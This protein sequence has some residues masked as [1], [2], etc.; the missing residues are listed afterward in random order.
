MTVMAVA[1]NREVLAQIEGIYRSRIDEFRRVARAVLGES[2]N[3][4][5]AVQDGFVRA[6]RDCHRFRG[7]GPLEGWVWG[8]V[9]N[10]IRESARALGK[11]RQSAASS[12]ALMD[13]VEHVRRDE[14]VRDAIQQLPERQRLALFLRH[15]AD[16]DYGEIAAALGIATGTVGATLHAAHAA[17][18]EALK[19]DLKGEQP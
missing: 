1:G 8:C 14:A 16:L 6:V 4:R 17:L 18:R 13:L 11:H 5:D 12:V 3:A 9:M 19:G 10:A 2:E 7:D 15:Y